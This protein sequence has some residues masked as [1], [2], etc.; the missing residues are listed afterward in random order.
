MTFLQKTPTWVSNYSYIAQSF[1]CNLLMHC[2][3]DENA[4]HLK[5]AGS[6]AW[7]KPGIQFHFILKNYQ[8]MQNNTTKWVHVVSYSIMGANNVGQ[9]LSV[10]NWGYPQHSRCAAVWNCIPLIRFPHKL[11]NRPMQPWTEGNL[12]WGKLNTNQ[13]N[14]TFYNSW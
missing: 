11:L 7:S 4:A 9:S 6:L 14:F 3:I 10:G 8:Q 1:L 2:C 5:C 12:S 13:L